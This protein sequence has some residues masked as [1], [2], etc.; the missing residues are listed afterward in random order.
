[1]AIILSTF[2][3]LEVVN[4]LQLQHFRKQM[5]AK[6][7]WMTL[8]AFDD[9]LRS[10]RFEVRMIPESVYPRARRLALQTTARLGTRTSDLFHIA[11]AL[12]LRA[13]GFFSFDKQQRALAK[14]VQLRLNPWR[15]LTGEPA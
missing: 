12:E 7:T 15:V 3:Q 2:A 4:A 14:T 1:V 13:D 9:D 8:E 10:G 6:E 5:T 11:S